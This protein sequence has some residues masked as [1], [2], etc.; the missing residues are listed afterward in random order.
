[1]T[2]FCANPKCGAPFRYL[3]RGSSLRLR[4]H[5]TP[6]EQSTSRKVEWFWLCE[7]CTRRLAIVFKPDGVL[8]FVLKKVTPAL[9]IAVMA[10]GDQLPAVL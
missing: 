1:M 3:T 7:R 5:R 2:G 8:A 6:R 9:T 10:L 4:E